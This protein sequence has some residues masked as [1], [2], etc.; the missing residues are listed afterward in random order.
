MPTAREIRVAQLTAAS[1]RAAPTVNP[2]GATPKA[3]EDAIIR[4]TQSTNMRAAAAPAMPAQPTAAPQP[5]EAD[6]INEESVQVVLGRI[7]SLENAVAV[8]PTGGVEVESV[9]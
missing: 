2:E 6:A 9:R 4:L 7:T 3:F 1:T 5:T 8:I